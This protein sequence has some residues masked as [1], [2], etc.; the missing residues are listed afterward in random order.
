[1]I[2][3]LVIFIT[4]MSMAGIVCANTALL[5]LD[6]C[7]G[8]TYTIIARDEFPISEGQKWED[9]KSQV[10]GRLHGKYALYFHEVKFTK[11][12]LRRA[13]GV[14]RSSYLGD[15]SPEVSAAEIA[16]IREWVSKDLKI[17]FVV[18]NIAK[19]R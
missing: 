6:L 11:P 16:L 3:K 18:P 19:A 8:D 2:K 1:M 15:S 13:F 10:W 7:M 5:K 9:I 14:D 4:F 17:K 12:G